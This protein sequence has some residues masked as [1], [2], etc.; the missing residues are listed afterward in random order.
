MIREIVRKEVPLELKGYIAGYNKYPSHNMIEI[1]FE[2]YMQIFTSE[3]WQYM[4]SRQVLD[5]EASY[6]ESLSVFMKE[7]NGEALGIAIAQNGGFRYYKFGE[8]AELDSKR[9]ELFGRD[10]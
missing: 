9:K 6:K 4:E 8:W 10:G 2:E 5:D 3:Y 7:L 1:S